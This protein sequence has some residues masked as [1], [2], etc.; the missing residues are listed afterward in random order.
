MFAS[1]RHIDQ[2]LLSETT[3]IRPS[4]STNNNTI[5]P[6]S[7]GCVVSEMPDVVDYV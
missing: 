5:S 6:T 7:V 4:E 3:N 2:H 1:P